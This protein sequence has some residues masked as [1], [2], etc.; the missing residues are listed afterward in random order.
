MHTRIILQPIAAPSILGLDLR[1]AGTAPGQLAGYGLEG[2]RRLHADR[3]GD[4]RLVHS[5]CTDVRGGF[6][7]IGLAGRH[8]PARSEGSDSQEM[9]SRDANRGTRHYSSAAMKQVHRTPDL[10]RAQR[11][12]SGTRPKTRLNTE[13]CEGKGTYDG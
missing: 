11:R 9:A 4:Q 3:L 10:K 7:K 5:E 1:R 6:G 2:R 13:S 12:R 8:D